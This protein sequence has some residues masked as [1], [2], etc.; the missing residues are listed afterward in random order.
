VDSASSRSIRRN[1][2]RDTARL[3]A[4]F[5]SIG[6][7]V[8][9][10]DE[11][12]AVSRINSVGLELLG[13]AEKDIMGK[14]FLD[15]IVAVYENG[16]PLT[17]MERPITKAFLSGR[18]IRARTIY[19]R[20]DGSFL[21]AQL[22][23]SPIIFEGKPIGAIEVFRDLSDEIENDKMKSDFISIASHQLRTPLSAVSMYTQMLRDGFAG[24][25]NDQQLEFVNIVLG[26]VGRMNELIDTL[27]NITRIE[28]GGIIPKIQEVSLETLVQSVI[29]ES[30]PDAE[31]KEIV[32]SSKLDKDLPNVA[33]DGLLVK[34]VY[35]NLLSN[36]IKYTAS[37][38]A[39]RICL[40]NNHSDITFSVRDSGYGIPLKSQKHIFTK[41][42]RAENVTRRDVSGTGL[43]LYLTKTI[44]DTLG[45]ELW[46]ESEEDVGTTFYFRLSKSSRRAKHLQPKPVKHQKNLASDI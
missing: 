26:S 27:L 25:I 31:E 29:A 11:D 33:T 4:L 22:T 45:G 3:E 20:R 10:T 15:K 13:Y 8:I 17:I 12:G 9:T 16:N 5:A 32:L 30:L 42:Y 34:E 7:G 37:G 46:F 1:A 21:P 2:T 23:V 28:A 19:K 6:E 24:S 14:R 18:T 40:A 39:I 44:A 36:A 41:F 43:G 35:A 38:G